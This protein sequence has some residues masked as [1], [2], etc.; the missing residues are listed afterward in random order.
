MLG[1]AHLL[2]NSLRSHMKLIKEIF[3]DALNQF[4]NDK[5]TKSKTIEFS[6]N[7]LDIISSCLLDA[8]DKQEERIKFRQE[9]VKRLDKKAKVLLVFDNKFLEELRALLKKIQ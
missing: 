6:R 2:H 5:E 7:E 9:Q 4:F 3:K 8:I 1:W